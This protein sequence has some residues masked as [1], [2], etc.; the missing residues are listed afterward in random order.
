VLKR[1]L[2][3]SL[4]ALLLA[5]STFGF[6]TQSK[7]ADP[8]VVRWRT[9]VDSADEQKVYQTISDKISKELES[10][11]ITL[12]Y[13]PQPVDGY[14]E[15][16]KTQLASDTAPDVFW[17]A[18]AFVASYATG[19]AILDLKDIA[20]AD[21]DFNV[22]DFYDA[23]MSEL[24]RQGSLWGLPRDVGP[25]VIYYNEDLFTA[26]GL[27]TP[28][29]LSKEGKW[30]WEAFNKAAVA[31]TD[32][33]AGVFGFG[34]DNWWGPW[35][36]WIYAAGGSLFNADNTA[37]ALNSEGTIKGLQALQDAYVKN[38][39]SP[40]PGSPSSGQA[41]WLAGKEGMFF[42][43]R[44]FTPAA[45]GA[46]FKWGV[47]EMPTGPGGKFT[48]G[49]WGAYTVNAKTKVSKEAWEVMKALT[50]AENQ[51]AIA[52]LGTNIPSRNSKAA[53]DEF[54]KATPPDDNSP[55]ISSLAYAKGEFAL[56]GGDLD[57]ILNQVIQPEL[58][59]VWQ[60]KLSPA[61][62][63]KTVCPLVDAKLKK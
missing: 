31:L 13:E 50:S 63:G 61:D 57:E 53:Q 51:G 33:S 49:F 7:A 46:K 22:K 54:L 20:A 10:K 23:P 32:E 55:F 21:K 35:G 6:S 15:N 18:G 37:C 24:A 11:G 9:R 40:L 4:V 25:L 17:V 30:D 5:A 56:W 8:V 1:K 62:F 41:L 45:R 38:K 2:I 36:Y 52:A 28:A 39:T 3:L 27:K 43:G 14:F 59:K 48:W 19:G 16:L 42:N 47:A 12:K 58:D 29:E 26:A 34:H 60:G 44:W